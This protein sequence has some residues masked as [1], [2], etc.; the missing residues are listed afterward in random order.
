MLATPD[1]LPSLDLR[2]RRR[3]KRPP[4]PALHSRMKRRQRL[5]NHEQLRTP[6][7]PTAYQSLPSC[8]ENWST[9]VNTTSKFGL[10]L[11]ELE[12]GEF[13]WHRKQGRP[14]K[15]ALVE[16]ALVRELRELARQHRQRRWEEAARDPLFLRDLAEIEAAFES[17]DAETARQIV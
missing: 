17:A 15:N 3:L 7:L 11:L 5:A 6:V 14:S 10:S 8:G 2:R 16:Q 4:E 13:G 9:L 1:P 12:A